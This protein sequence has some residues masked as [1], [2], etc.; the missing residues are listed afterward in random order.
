[1]IFIGF[2]F[3]MTFLKKYGFSSVGYNFVLSA[4]VIQW[5]M[6][7]TNFSGQ[8]YAVTQE[9]AEY[10]KVKLNIHSLIEGDFAS[11]CVLITMGAVLGKTTPTQLLIIAVLEVIFYAINFTIGCT[12]LQTV[13]MGG[14]MFVHTFGAYFG[15]G[16]S[17]ALSRSKKDSSGG[18]VSHDM[19]GS[20]STSDMFAMIGTIFLWMFWPSFNGGF[21][22]GDQ[23]YRVVINTVLSLSACCVT[24][25]AVD[26]HLR[27]G[28][29]FSMVSIQ[30]ATL[31][32]GVAVGSSS[33][34]IIHPWGAILIGCAAGMLSVVGY[35]YIQPWLEEKLGLDDTCGVHNLHGMPGILGGLG[36]AIA[37]S[38]ASEEAYGASIGNVFSARLPVEEGGEGR[39]A[40]DQAAFQVAALVITVSVS[41]FS[42]YITGLVVKLPCFR[43]PAYDS[44]EMAMPRQLWYCDDLY[45]ETEEDTSLAI[46]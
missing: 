42:G 12:H 29:K 9:D 4:F 41:L 37:S 19:N 13:D 45:W 6:V 33:D 43:P 34:L 26:S 15:L 38:M 28:N 2:G 10:E 32:G 39:T 25:F 8:A 11:G 14:S 1:M 18:V 46:D 7:V 24:A 21:A 44:E 5:A 17:R 3:L 16:V 20:T 40:G 31:A 27:P 23:Q 35:V 22:H 36:G 30:N